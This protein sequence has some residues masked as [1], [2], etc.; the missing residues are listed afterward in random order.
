MVCVFFLLLIYA[1]VYNH[2]MSIAW[3]INDAWQEYQLAYQVVHFYSMRFITWCFPFIHFSVCM[4]VFDGD[5]LRA[6]GLSFRDVK[7]TEDELERA[8]R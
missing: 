2:H 5:N 6:F 4:G 8:L 7:Y 1:C 3:V